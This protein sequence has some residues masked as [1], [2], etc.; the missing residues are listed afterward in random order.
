[1]CALAGIEAAALTDHNTV[2]NCAAFCE[3][4]ERY[5]ILA[6][7]GMELTTAEEVHVVCVFGDLDA[8]QAFEA[9]V[10]RRLPPLEN[11]PRV[12]GPQVKMDSEDTVLGE[13]R[14]MLATATGIGIYEV[15]GLVAS[16]GGACWPAHID[17]PSFSLIS[18]LGLWDPDLG[19][20]FAEVSRSCPPDFLDRPDLKGLPVI[21]A[22]DAHYLDQVMDACQKVSLPE[23]N[24]SSLLAW[25]KCPDFN[26][27]SLLQS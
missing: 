17:R 21:T 9:E 23:K 27:Y 1:M 22:S 2:G 25:L 8:A 14:R 26:A 10:F 15:P 13:E 19:F 4:A 5:G 12:F 20:S 11:D 18:N 6:L 16:L 3:A 24:F 7:P